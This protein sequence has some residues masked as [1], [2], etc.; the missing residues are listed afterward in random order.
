M[1]YYFVVYLKLSTVRGKGGFYPCSCEGLDLFFYSLFELLF[2][3]TLLK[4]L[5]LWSYSDTGVT[6]K[7]RST[8]LSV[9]YHGYA[10]RLEDS[11]MDGKFFIVPGF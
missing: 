8:P 6:S 3:K 4:I 7:T 9:P 11:T 10:A 2:L 1:R 5:V